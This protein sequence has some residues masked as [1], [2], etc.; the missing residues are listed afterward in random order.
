MNWPNRLTIFRIVLI[1]GFIVAIVY[2]KL[3]IAFIIFL[4]AAITDAL[5]GYIARVR[6]E[7]TKLGSILD[8]IAD[9]LLITSAFITYSFL[10]EIPL[11]LKMPIYI[12][13]IVVSRDIIILLGTMI[14]YL[15]FDNIDIKPTI[16]GKITTFFQMC[17]II[18]ILLRFPYSK[19]IWNITAILTVI[20]GLNYVKIGTK[21]INERV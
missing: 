3:E 9:K 2:K 6:N 21:Y 18:V 17:T 8:P 19:W 1:P 5:D 12:P 14:I 10:A 16:I 11:N 15:L 4:I 20:S 13:I 7:K